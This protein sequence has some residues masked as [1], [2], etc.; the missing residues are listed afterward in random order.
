MSIGNFPE[1]LSPAIL[2]GRLGVALGSDGVRETEIAS[3]HLARCGVPSPVEGESPSRPFNPIE[4][5]L[6]S[7]TLASDP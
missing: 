4:A 6:R 1:S 7:Q 2:S 3:R 5:S